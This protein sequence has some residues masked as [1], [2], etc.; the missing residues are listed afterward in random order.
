M[1]TDDLYNALIGNTWKFA[2]QSSLDVD[3]I[4]QELY[5]ICMEV[6]EGRSAYS[7][8][9]GGVDEY[10][11]GRLWG[12]IRRWPH[13]QMLEDLIDVN[14]EEEIVPDALRVLSTENV[15]MLKHEL[16]EQNA[17]DVEERYKRQDRLRDQSTLSI[18]IQ[19]GHW[20]IREAARF[21]RVSR[22][23]IEQ[24]LRNVADHSAEY[25]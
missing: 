17:I 2:A 21:F 7:P 23:S 18:L 22:Y 11:L 20:S 24:S 1:K 6:S 5:L 9:V 15:V 10:I 25:R 19:N 14:C 4:K 16:H 3:D 12:L 13:S 8:L